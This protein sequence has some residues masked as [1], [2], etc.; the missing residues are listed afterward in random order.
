M[1]G[2]FLLIV[3]LSLLCGGDMVCADAFSPIIRSLP[4]KLKEA[5]PSPQPIG[6]DD[7]GPKLVGIRR[8]KNASGEFSTLASL[9]G[10]EAGKIQLKK[11]DGQLISIDARQLHEEDQRFLRETWSLS[12]TDKIHLGVIAPDELT[13]MADGCHRAGD[14]LAL[15]EAFL[16]APNLEDALRPQLQLRIVDL[17]QAAELQQVKL[18]SR[19]VSTGEWNQARQ[20]QI[21]MLSD[22]ERTHNP[23]QSQEF[24]TAIERAA[25]EVPENVHPSFL[26]GVYHI[27]VSR[28]PKYAIIELNRCE[29]SLLARQQSLAPFEKAN[30]VA[31]N[32]NLSV[33]H[34]RSGNVATAIA[35]MTRLREYGVVPVETVQN[36]RRMIWLADTA[37]QK[38]MARG[39]GVLST[40]QRG[41]L[42]D[43]IAEAPTSSQNYQRSW[44]L[45]SY[46]ESVPSDDWRDSERWEMAPSSLL[47]FEDDWCL[48]CYGAG[49]VSCPVTGC[50]GGTVRSYTR[51]VTQTANGPIIH[52]TP[53]RAP[54]KNCRGTGGVDCP[55]CINGKFR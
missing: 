4:P 45:M 26:L 54:C 23:Q 37:E 6:V 27:Q 39:T 25:R 18:N 5:L 12:P 21:R 3:V 35:C 33:A 20:R 2:C 29:R 32:H 41:Q 40:R 36:I 44:K 1:R 15:Y 38:G 9:E 24:K 50:S 16:E 55:M 22:A 10:I 47:S 7:A 11:E 28:L 49:K 30:L 34:L 13:E 43:I 17:K 46:V 19:W 31:V 8:W 14:A 53:T 48:A 51:T 42:L 52:D